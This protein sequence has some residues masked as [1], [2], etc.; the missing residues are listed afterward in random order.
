MSSSVQRIRLPSVNDIF[1]SVDNQH[2]HHHHIQHYAPPAPQVMNTGFQINPNYIAQPSYPQQPIP[3]QVQHQPQPIVQQPI[4]FNPQNFIVPPPHHQQPITPS[5]SPINYMSSN[6][7][8]YPQQQYQYHQPR[9]NINNVSKYKIQKSPT[10]TRQ[11]NAW[12]A[13]DDELLKY[14][15][16]VKNLGWREISMYFQN[17]TANGC[18]FRWRRIVALTKSSSSPPSSS[19]SSSPLPEKSQDSEIEVS[20]RSNSLESLLN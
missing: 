6:S 7:T 9:M 12:S 4:P 18:Q 15:K 8:P 11:S 3:I 2:H 10:S 16:E 20:M 14:L 1:P 5:Q 13:N 19:A 17:R